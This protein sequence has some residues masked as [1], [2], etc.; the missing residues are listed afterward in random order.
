MIGAAAGAANTFASGE[1]NGTPPNTA[2][3]TG[4]TPIWA[5]IDNASGSINPR[6][7]GSR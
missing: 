5:A 7:P 2:K 6:G 4:S 1:I 3:V